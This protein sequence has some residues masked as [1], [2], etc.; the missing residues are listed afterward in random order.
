MKNLINAIS[1]N[2][3][4]ELLKDGWEF[5]LHYGDHKTFCDIQEACW[6]ADFTRLINNGLWD[7]HESGYDVD[8]NIAINIA[9]KNIK[10][11]IRLKK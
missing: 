11:G 7:N 9:Y 10:N 1:T 2:Q 8:P 5:M 3:I 4:N 6:E